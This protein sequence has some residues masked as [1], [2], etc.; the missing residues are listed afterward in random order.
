MGIAGNE[1]RCGGAG[2]LNE[3][4]LY[5]VA[6]FFEEPSFFS[7]PE[8][9]ELA[10]LAGPD[11]IDAGGRCRGAVKTQQP[12]PN[13]ENKTNHDHAFFLSRNANEL[14]HSVDRLSCLPLYFRI[15]CRIKFE[16]VL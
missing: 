4:Q 13:R 15:D 7:D 14:N 6:V 8:R 5:A 11:N 3:N 9:R 12:G 10:D 2:A 16:E 1:C